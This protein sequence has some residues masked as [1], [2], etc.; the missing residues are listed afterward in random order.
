MEQVTAVLAQMME[1]IRGMQTQQANL[2]R[3]LLEQGTKPV[4]GIN[5]QP[6]DEINESFSSYLQRL[7]NYVTLKGGRHYKITNIFKLH[8]SAILS[9]FKKHY[10]TKYT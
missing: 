4:S 6:Y 9:S 10:G 8:W 1:T 3:A 7:H 5:L 2:Q